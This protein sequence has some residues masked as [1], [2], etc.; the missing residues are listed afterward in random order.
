MTAECISQGQTY[1]F[2]RPLH[3]TH[4]ASNTKAMLSCQIFE[5]TSL[6]QRNAER[7]SAHEVSHPDTSTLPFPYPTAA[8]LHHSL[9][10]YREAFVCIALGV[11]GFELPNYKCLPYLF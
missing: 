3:G 8:N 11:L 9:S 6:T 10:F 5:A 1:D 2:A 4:L 7:R